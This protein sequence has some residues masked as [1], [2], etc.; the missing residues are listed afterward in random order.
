[1]YPLNQYNNELARKHGLNQKNQGNVNVERLEEI[2]KANI[3]SE[4]VTN[5]SF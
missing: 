1:M 5:E 2:T 3:D 4:F